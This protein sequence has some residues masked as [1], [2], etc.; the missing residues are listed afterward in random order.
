MPSLFFFFFWFSLLCLL[1]A[2]L[3][4][5]GFMLVVTSVG[6]WLKRKRREKGF[7]FKKKKIRKWVKEK[8]RGSSFSRLCLI[9]GSATGEELDRLTV[10]GLVGEDFLGSFFLGLVLA[11]V[12]WVSYRL[13]GVWS[14]EGVLEAGGDSLSLV[15]RW[16]WKWVRVGGWRLVSVCVVKWED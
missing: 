15:R 8:E 4:S 3:V 16:D 1:L 7:R 14:V 9:G 10:V 5:S 13:R 11:V 12:A 6:I 2:V